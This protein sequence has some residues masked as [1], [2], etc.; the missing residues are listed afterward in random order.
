MSTRWERRADGMDGGGVPSAPGYD[1]GMAEATG[2][3][4]VRSTPRLRLS[5][6]TYYHSSTLPWRR[7]R[8][9]NPHGF[10][11][12]RFSGP[13]STPL[14]PSVV[15]KVGFEP[16]REGFTDPAHSPD[17]LPLVRAVGFEP[18]PKLVLRQRPLPIGLRTVG[19]TGRIRTDTDQF[20]RLVPLPLGYS[21]GDMIQ[22]KW[23]RQQGLEPATR[24][25]RG[26]RSTD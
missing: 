17:V 6:P 25:L 22:K 16:T 26:S 2:I 21:G 10:W 11:P 19:T 9:S 14:R 18:T 5:K 1:C 3:E 24:S 20:L 4:P 8:D 7:V 15:G 23:S 12:S 13:I